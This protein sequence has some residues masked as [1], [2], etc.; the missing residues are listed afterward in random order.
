MTFWMVPSWLQEWEKE[1]E[2]NGRVSKKLRKINKRN[3]R[4]FYGEI[5]ELPF[6]VK[7]RIGWYIMWNGKKKGV[8]G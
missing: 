6:W 7:I 3:W 4:Q 1:Q 2:M 5:L 8:K